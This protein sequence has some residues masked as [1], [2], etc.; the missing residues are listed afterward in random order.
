MNSIKV[1]R[2]KNK[3]FSEHET[4]AGGT[5]CGSD[6]QRRTKKESS[7]VMMPQIA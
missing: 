3:L 2:Q 7:R 5:E 6:Y 1:E 4:A